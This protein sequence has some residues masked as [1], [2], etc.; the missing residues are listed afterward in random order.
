MCNI[1]H[2]QRHIYVQHHS[3]ATLMY[4]QNLPVC[5]VLHM[6]LYLM[7]NIRHLQLYLM[8][9]IMHKQLY[10]MCNITHLHCQVRVDRHVCMC[11]TMSV[12]VHTWRCVR[13]VV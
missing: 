11:S 9:Y 2:V 1:M 13:T 3:H 12:W 6:Q 7:C 5:N 10:F 4:V 8:C